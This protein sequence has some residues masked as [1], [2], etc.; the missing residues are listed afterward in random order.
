MR[1][2]DCQEA[3]ATRVLLNLRAEKAYVR[4]AP[5]GTLEHT[6]RLWQSSRIK[7]EIRISYTLVPPA[8]ASIRNSLPVFLIAIECRDRDLLREGSPRTW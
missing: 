2:D 4:T 8:H 3:Q 7:T 6:G 1:I 5:P